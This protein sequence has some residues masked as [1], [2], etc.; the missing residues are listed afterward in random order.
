MKLNII[1]IFDISL[2]S[3]PRNCITNGRNKISMNSD[4]KRKDQKFPSLTE[5]R[6]KF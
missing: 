5:T 6:Y 1:V 3:T 2:K 4:C